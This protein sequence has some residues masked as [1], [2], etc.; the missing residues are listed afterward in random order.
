MNFI[1]CS[2]AQILCLLPP[3]AP[4]QHWLL[5][6]GKKNSKTFIASF[7]IFYIL[8]YIINSISNQFNGSTSPQFFFCEVLNFIFLLANIYLTNFFLGGRFIRFAYNQSIH[9]FKGCILLFIQKSNYKCLIQMKNM[10]LRLTETQNRL[11]VSSDTEVGCSNTW[12]RTRRIDCTCQTPSA[13]SFPPS[14]GRLTCFGIQDIIL[15]HKARF[16]SSIL[17][18]CFSS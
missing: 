18:Y 16:L 8:W 7:H 13:H 6:P 4:S 17:R 11:V 5:H 10:W 2:I 3:H 15:T 9:F 12:R 14:Q 1:L